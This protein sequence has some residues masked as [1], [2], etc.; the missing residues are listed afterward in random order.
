MKLVELFARH[1][2]T[3]FINIFEREHVAVEDLCHL[4]DDDLR[5]TFGMVA[6]M[7][8][9][10]F[11]AMVAEL[12]VA[13]ASRA[14]AVPTI[15]PTRTSVPAPVV[16]P[17]GGTY[18]GQPARAHAA[19]APTPVP[20][21]GPDGSTY[22][23]QP[24]VVANSPVVTMGAGGR[25]VT[26]ATGVQSF[27]DVVSAVPTQIGNY[28]VLGHV[29]AGGMGTVLRAR[30][31]VEAWAEKQGGDVAIKLIHP[32]L[33]ADHS[34]QRRF[35]DE[36]LLGRKV[37]HAGLVPTWDVV[38]EGPWIGTVMGFVSGEPLTSRVQAG[39][40]AL[41]KVLALLAPVGEVLDHL[42]AQGIVHRDVKP[43]NG[44]VRAD[45]RPVL[46]DLGIAKDTSSKAETHTS[47]LATV[48]TR[49]WMAPEQSL[50]G[51]AVEGA[52]DRYAFGLLAYAL[53]TGRMPWPDE[54]S[55]DSIVALKAMG[56]LVPLHV[57]RDGLP[58]HVGAAVMKMLSTLPAERYTSCAM[59]VAAMRQSEPSRS[60]VAT[61][62]P[63][64]VTH[65][66]ESQPAPPQRWASMMAGDPFENWNVAG[67]ILKLRVVPPRTFIMGS[68]ESQQGRGA[69]ET[70]HS[71]TLT[72]GYSIGVVPVTQGLWKAVRGNNPAA[73]RGAN[74]AER[75]VE[76]ISWY[77]AIRFCNSLSVEAGLRPVYEL[78]GGDEGRYVKASARRRVT[79]DPMADGFRLPTE[80]EWECAA[81][82][83]MLGKRHV[84]AGSDVWGEVG[85]FGENQTSPVMQQRPNAWGLYDM[86]GNVC[87]WCWDP[88]GEYP[89]TP[90]TDP[91]GAAGEIGADG[92]TI[93]LPSRVHRGGS[94]A[95]SPLRHGRTAARGHDFPGDAKDHIGFRLARTIL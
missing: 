92:V 45:G 53:L 11:K 12:E 60:G 28:R 69:D 54:V 35:L 31:V 63:V 91:M 29:G 32:H 86:S 68:P 15:A 75:P 87:E 40:V 64:T 67:H 36:A 62:A 51:R 46:L 55:G 90:V 17:D 52:A 43:A 66:P 58:R 83:G 56:E 76:N 49:A 22:V 88:Y 73:K 70:E 3:Q 19:P 41:D 38:V 16:G 2:L 10:R 14:P 8:R 94:W 13:T 1:G 44:M 18:V 27:G 85:W 34:F 37:Q 26:T 4:S 71:V 89:R 30:H 50:P 77:A 84:Y 82:A 7:D 74:G 33:A 42:H 93:E 72:R 9:K 23:L 20:A 78:D 25:T 59:F 24:D 47:V 95:N 5:A 61:S 65:A 81:S 21:V 79:F 6:F 57:A 39:G 80:A 48:G